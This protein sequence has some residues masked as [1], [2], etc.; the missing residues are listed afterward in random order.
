LRRADARHGEAAALNERWSRTVALRRPLVTWKFAATLDGR[1]AA[2]DGT[3]QWIT[4]E[5][6]RADV[7]SLRAARSRAGR[8]RHCARRRP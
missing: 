8:D 4:G 2:A 6:A 7:H 1:T 5:A 3:S